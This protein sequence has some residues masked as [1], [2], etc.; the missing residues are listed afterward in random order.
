MRFTLPVLLLTIACANP[1]R[2]L[3]QCK[4]VV[5]G[6]SGRLAA[7]LVSQHNWDPDTATQAE[8]AYDAAIRAYLTRLHAESAWVADTMVGEYR[9]YMHG[10]NTLLRTCVAR[11]VLAFSRSG[12]TPRPHGNESP[13][14]AMV[15]VC[16]Q[17]FP[18]ADQY[19]LTPGFFD[20]LTIIA[21]S[22]RK[23]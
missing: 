14:D 17:R 1:V 2:D 21:G 20:S 6:A 7:C 5:A 15:R 22:P 23:S 8:L 10:R 19:P 12:E 3:A 13:V 16:S 9:R 4:V 18:D 11:F